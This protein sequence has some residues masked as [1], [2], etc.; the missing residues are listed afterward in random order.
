MQLHAR[1]VLQTLCHNL[2]L[3]KLLVSQRKVGKLKKLKSADLSAKDSSRNVS[4]LHCFRYTLAFEHFAS[5]SHNREQIRF[6]FRGD[7]PISRE[8]S[9]VSLTPQGK[10]PRYQC[11]SGVFWKFESWLET[12][13]LLDDEVNPTFFKKLSCIN[14][15]RESRYRGVQLSCINDTRESRYALSRIDLKKRN[16]NSK[17]SFLLN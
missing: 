16:S 1:R 13:V 17:R 15:T 3:W 6:Q 12:N 11:Y 7:F 14:D 9:A 8:N 2:G 4:L 5:F 10:V